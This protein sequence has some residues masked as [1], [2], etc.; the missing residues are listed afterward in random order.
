MIAEIVSE[1][2]SIN[3]EETA[4]NNKREK[5]LF[6]AMSIKDEEERNKIRVFIEDTSPIKQVNLKEIEDLRSVIKDLE[7]KILNL[8]EE[9]D[10][11]IEQSKNDKKYV[12]TFKE[13]VF[14]LKKHV[15]TLKKYLS[16]LSKGISDVFNR[17]V[18][19]IKYY[20]ENIIILMIIFAVIGAVVFG[21]IYSNSNNQPEPPIN[22]VGCVFSPE[23][24]SDGLS[25]AGDVWPDTISYILNGMTEINPQVQEYI[26]GYSNNNSEAIYKLGKC[27]E[28]G[29]SLE[30]NRNM[31]VAGY[32]VHIAANQGYAPAQTRLGL[33]FYYG[34]GGYT[35]DYD[36]SRFWLKEAI[37]NGSLDAK[38]YMGQA[39]DT[40]R[41]K[42]HNSNSINV[43][44]DKF[45]AKRLY[46]ESAEE[47]HAL[48]QLYLGI[49]YW[50]NGNNNKCYSEAREWIEKSLDG[51]LPDN[52]KSKAFLILGNLYNGS[53]S[54]KPE[55]S[56]AYYTKAAT[57]GDGNVKAMYYLGECYEDGDGTKQDFAKAEEWYKKAAD[58]G[59][60]KAIKKV[61]K[62]RKKKSKG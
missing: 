11:I 61:E 51:N 46:I 5:L 57:T 8:K 20:S 16:P 42:S 38:F 40:G 7:G 56:F 3:L 59:Y 15:F 18:D 34:C 26:D 22:R 35:C 28:S 44:P 62:M 47:G 52:E 39:Y 24:F 17:I 4:V 13:C 2:E 12:F 14:I 41:F 45:L 9:N 48:S 19:F 31:K 37:K 21:V 1:C 30:G 25:C 36:S 10:T 33:Y 27:F 60:K 53:Y 49:F 32:L 50:S 6:K 23:D 55:M 29:D 43:G 58:R 54:N